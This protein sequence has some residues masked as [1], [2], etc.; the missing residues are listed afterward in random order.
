MDTG[1]RLA[2]REEIPA[3][4]EIWRVCFH[5]TED[6]IRFFYRENFD[7]LSAFVYT[8]DDRPVSMLH[9]MD[10]CFEDGAERLEAKFLYA[11]GT[12]PAY[13]KNGYYRALFEHV[14]KLAKQNGFLLFGKPASWDL[15]PYYRSIG[16][17]PDACFRL[18]TLRP[19]PAVPLS[20]SPLSAEAYNRMR[21]RAFGGRPYAVW[22]DRHV[23]FCIAESEWFGGKTLAVETGGGLCFLMGAPENDAF[24]ITETD[25]PLPELR[26]ISGALCG[27][28]GAAFLKA[29]LPEDACGE[30]ERILSSVIYNAPPRRT[31]VNLIL[32]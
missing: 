9:W 20:V 17:E 26:R 30:G 3:L 12:L 25:L 7:F 29:Y 11:G 24:V 14:K 10:S 2:R 6:Y 1:I 16:L 18:V 13:R 23:R 19:G 28:F 21:N 4:T 22:P 5:D 27:M 31:Y 15:L 8:V 32:N